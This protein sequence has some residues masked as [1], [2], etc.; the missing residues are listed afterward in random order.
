MKTRYWLAMLLVYAPAIHAGPLV[1]FDTLGPLNQF[2]PALGL[3]V[4]TAF[5]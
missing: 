5:S 2:N 1:L 4:A 3:T